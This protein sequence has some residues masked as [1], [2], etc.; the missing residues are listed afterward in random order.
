MSENNS[1][2][3]SGVGRREENES[4]IG[5]AREQVYQ[6]QSRKKTEKKDEKASKQKPVYVRTETK[7]R[8]RKCSQRASKI[9]FYCYWVARQT[10]NRRTEGL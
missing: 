5:T 10:T 2:G 4:E 8:P 1:I 9:Y 7:A 3:M 6:K